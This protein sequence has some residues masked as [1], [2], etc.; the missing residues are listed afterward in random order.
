MWTRN[1]MESFHAGSNL[2]DIIVMT[3]KVIQ[4]VAK[5]QN[6]EIVFQLESFYS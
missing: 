6:R 5:L 1:P 2:A 4:Y 3:P